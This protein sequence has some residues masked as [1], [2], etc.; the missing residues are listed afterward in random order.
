MHTTWLKNKLK[1]DSK[2]ADTP[3][4]A[5][6]FAHAFAGTAPQSSTYLYAS[7]YAKIYNFPAP[8]GAVFGIVGFGGGLYGQTTPIPNSTYPTFKLILDNRSDIFKSWSLYGISPSAFPTIYIVQL[9]AGNVPRYDAATAENTLDVTTIGAC[10]PISTATIILYLA[11]NTSAG[12]AAAFRAAIYGTRI[13]RYTTFRPTVI[14][15]SWGGPENIWP[16][17]DLVG[18]GLNKILSQSTVPI[19]VATGDSGATNGGRKA[20][21]NYPASSP[22][23][24]ACGGT[25]LV[26]PTR[27]YSGQGTTETAWNYSAYSRQGGGGGYS[28]IYKRPAWQ[29]ALAGSQPVIAASGMRAIPDIAMNADPATGI[30]MYFGGILRLGYGGTS[31]VS[32]AM[33]A[34]IGCMNTPSITIAKL[35]KALAYPPYHDVRSG[36]IGEGINAVTGYDCCTG[37]GSIDGK[38]MLAA[39]LNQ[40]A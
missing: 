19:C 32:P 27:S 39:I 15:C 26:C 28:Q 38:A 3:L 20:N 8:R 1:S 31:I 10:C 9:G 22:Y 5:I 36:T 24:I 17:N 40:K 14:S 37:I 29:T 6:S 2:P 34:L 33:A 30:Q 7:D 11:P 18:N 13:N 21:V 25:T 35:Y 12:W 16:N 4:S 23:V